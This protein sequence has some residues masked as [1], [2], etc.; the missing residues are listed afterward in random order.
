MLWTL[1][2]RW[3]S[4]VV[5]FVSMVSGVPGV[6]QDVVPDLSAVIGIDRVKLSDP[7]REL[8]RRNGFVVVP[9]PYHQIYSPYIHEGLPVFVTTDALFHTYHVI[10]ERQIARLEARLAADVEFLSKR[11][12]AVLAG[13]APPDESAVE[14]DGRRLALGCVAVAVGLLDPSHA[15][16]AEVAEP[17]QAEL[18]LVRAASGLAASPLFGYP[19][20]YSMTRPRGFYAESAAL[21]RYFQCVSWYGRAAFRLV[22]ATETAAALAITRAYAEDPESVAVFGRL[23]DAYREFLGQQDDLTLIEYAETA[24]RVQSRPRAERLTAFVDAARALRDP[25][26]HDMAVLAEPPA[27]WQQLTK[28]L[29]V[30]GPRHIPDS[31]VFQK[32]V[33]PAVPTRLLPSGLDLM[34]ANGSTRA[35]ELLASLEVAELPGYAAGLESAE[36]LIAAL[37]LEAEPDNYT[38]FLCLV[39]AVTT[40]RE[41]EPYAFMRSPAWED[42]KLNT[43]LGAWASTRH[44]W[45]LQAKQSD[46]YPC[47]FRIQ[48]G[49]VEPAPL[50]YACLSDLIQ[51]TIRTLRPLGGFDIERLQALDELVST[52]DAIA[53][54][55]VRREVLTAEEGL[56]VGDFPTTIAALGYTTSWA[57]DDAASPTARIVDVH[58]S[59]DPRRHLEPEDRCLQVGVGPAYA[60][61]VVMRDGEQLQLAVGGVYSYREF[62]QPTRDRLTD[63]AWRDA[64]HRGTIPPAPVWTGSFIA[65]LDTLGLL[66]RIE[67]GEVPDDLLG[68]SDPT[69]LAAL[70]AGVRRGIF[71]DRRH[72]AL[73]MLARK[74]GAQSIPLLV[75]L[76]REHATAPP[77]AGSDAYPIAW[78]LTLAVGPEHL[79][80]FEALI[81]DPSIVHAAPLVEVIAA[82]G[83]VAAEQALARLLED[84]ES[85]PIRDAVLRALV[86]RDSSGAGAISLFVELGRKDRHATSVVLRELSRVWGPQRVGRRPH[87]S[88][89]EDELSALRER[90]ADWLGEV[91][92]TGDP[93]VL[94]G[95]TQ[96][97]IQM[98]S[99]EHLPAIEARLM[100]RSWRSVDTATILEIGKYPAAVAVPTLVRLGGKLEVDA[101]DG[102][103]QLLQQLSAPECAR[104]LSNYLDDPTRPRVD[105]LRVCDWAAFALKQ[106]YPDGPDFSLEADLSARD[107]AI[108]AWKGFLQVLHR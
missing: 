96:L 12:L 6:A 101:Q 48:P 2:F 47:F 9:R 61:F 40:R 31:Q 105:R 44:T 63:A 95:A 71:V 58:T 23:N 76:F 5:L 19:V 7:A 10:M 100:A 15:P 73:R 97:S 29:R 107:Q 87:H 72:E 74:R 11:L 91:I 56:T 8:L 90:V 53:E 104:E 34:A 102:L 30:I 51:H 75:E 62:S 24:A 92:R 25:T 60:M 59:W 108:S 89:S 27:T 35:R 83:G 65:E 84:F 46:G 43:A 41:D 33:D 26:I 69:L 94:V 78:A 14:R 38:R 67:A 99:F 86:S 45:V 98:G 16:P 64:C 42:Q 22:S 103:I 50:F 106:I 37:K 18:R 82:T 49:W 4:V 21:Q 79:A 13:P 20:D 32:L 52:L 85:Q 54:K 3:V 17:V 93:G 28:G 70:E 55:Q 88:L 80:Q 57:G 81:R 68:A 39:E 36:L 77:P 66:R 1:A